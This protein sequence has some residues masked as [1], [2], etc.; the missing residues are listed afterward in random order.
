[1][2]K[3]AR[4]LPVALLLILSVNP[5]ARGINTV[6]TRMMSQPAIS[7]NRI[8]F[9]YA[10]DLWVC[11]ID[12]SNPRRL[13]VDE[14]IESNPCFSPDGSLIAFSAQY[15]G[16]TDVFIVPADGGVPKRL[17]W[18]PG[19]DYPRG[20]TPDGKQVL[21]A[22]QRSSFT[23]RYFQLFTVGTGGGFPEK[24]K[25][26][27]A[28]FAAYSPDGNSLAYT[29]LSPAY[30][31]W[32][33]YRGGRIS[34]IWLCSLSDYSIVNVPQPEGG[35]NDADPMWIGNTIYFTSDRN[36][37]F[38]LYSCNT[39]TRE[40]TQLTF[41]NDFPILKAS[42]G[43]DRIV[44][45]Q[46]GYLHT[47]D[48]KTKAVTR[49]KIGIAADLLELRPRFV[50]GLRYIRSSDISPTGSRIVVDFRGD[51]VTVPAEK[52]DP[53]N[54]TETVNVHET[55]PSWSPDGKTV[56]YI[57]DASGE[58]M[59]H[60]KPQD[61]KGEARVIK[62][63]GTGFYAF[64]KWSPD[65]RKICYTDNAR[66]LYILD[67]ASGAIS[68]IGSDDL[69]SPGQF[70]TMFNDWSSDSKWIAYTRLMETNFR[71]VYLYSTD[72]QKS[73]QVTDGLSDAS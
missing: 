71:V 1:M 29:P 25:I 46:A 57:S 39:G 5:V 26:P 16:N 12:G 68:K 19:G 34:R 44:F 30:Q 47:F 42:S 15:D 7:A 14:G 45:E 59:L 33:N 38:N 56:A 2:K 54:L 72:Q 35:C 67:V 22:S 62:L 17:T 70:R 37:E 4:S 53:R 10:E 36:G 27:T 24:L 50:Q 13:T 11:N 23:N 64:P 55:Y 32:K 18:H 51:I 28:W 52:G 60:L 49:V 40:I 48:I 69:Y 6:D 31:Q 9:I 21:F 61:G 73:F 8:A 43:S 65:S 3:F 58:Y 41:F 63:T 20:F 66:N